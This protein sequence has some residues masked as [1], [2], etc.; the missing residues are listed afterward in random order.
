MIG[1]FYNTEGE[2]AGTAS[3]DAA[4]TKNENSCQEILT[5]C[6]KVNH[7][8]GIKLI[9][10]CGDI[11]RLRIS[12]DDTGFNLELVSNSEFF[13]E[14]ARWLVPENAR[15]TIFGVARCLRDSKLA[16]D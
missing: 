3:A 7:A 1:L 16:L 5:N 4:K 11:R 10:S 14:D 8:N 9:I 2:T 15:M 6:S 12:S 13:D